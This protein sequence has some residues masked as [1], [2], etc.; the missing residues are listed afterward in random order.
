MQPPHSL[1]RSTSRLE[2][3]RPLLRDAADPAYCCPIPCPWMIPMPRS[4]LA[5]TAVLSLVAL[6]AGCAKETPPP[7]PPQAA[8]V[9]PPLP[10]PPEAPWCARPA[11]ISAFSVAALKSHLMVAAISCRADDKYNAFITRYRPA[12]LQQEKATA[13]YFDRG[14]K[15]HGQQMRDSYVTNLANAQSN[16]AMV[17]GSQF[18]ERSMGRFDEVMALSKPDDLPAFA[19]TKTDTIPQAMKFSECPAAA[20]QPEKPAAKKKK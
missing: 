15:R 7:P 4:A 14:D 13:S 2:G 5:R 19:A 12:L 20:A 17:L 9:P 16:R 3:R 18:C 11:E 6:L 1:Q 8:Y 10:D